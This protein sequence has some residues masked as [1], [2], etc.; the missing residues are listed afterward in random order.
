MFPIP[1]LTCVCFLHF[2]LAAVGAA[3]PPM[4]TPDAPKKPVAPPKKP[5]AGTV[6][7]FFAQISSI[8][9]EFSFQFSSYRPHFNALCNP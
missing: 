5:V 9:P 1:L 3:P 2:T 6:A 8:E 4:K 7:A